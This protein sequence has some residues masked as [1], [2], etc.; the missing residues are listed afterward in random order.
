[1]N[2]QT[3]IEFTPLEDIRRVDLQR[4]ALIEASAG[5]G[6]TYTI[7]NLVVRLLEEEP[8]LTLEQILLVTFTEKATGE[9]KQR[10]RSKIEEALDSHRI[11]DGNSQQK[12]HQALERF[13]SAAITTIHGFC[14]TLLREFPF[15]T[16]N[17]FQQELVDDAPLTEKL[18][19]RQ[20]RMDWPRRFGRRLSTLLDLAGFSGAP[21]RFMGTVLDLHRHLSHDPRAQCLIPDPADLELDT[22][23]RAAEN[24]IIALRQL[25][26]DTT[27]W[28]DGYG[29][30][31]IN[32]RSKNA[33]IRD[34]VEPLCQ[35]LAA[36]D[37]DRPDLVQ[38]R[39]LVDV[40]VKRH[41][42]GGRNI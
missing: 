30:L 40:L 36:M 37:E 16:G 3:S 9:L 39:P 6:K 29:R 10:I 41:T 34:M 2:T 33:I 13:D 27:C 7:E 28:I 4:H 23:W 20:I 35:M 24:A 38:F 5:T 17:L 18:L 1:M 21:D 26:G 19:Q 31:N 12:L 8:D 14:H 11:T 42:S 15:E 32:K 25:I 22:L